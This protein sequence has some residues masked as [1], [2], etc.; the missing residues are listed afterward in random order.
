MDVSTYQPVVW[1]EEEA[2]E[3]ATVF[4]KQCDQKSEEV[5]ADV[6]ETK[7][8]VSQYPQGTSVISSI[9]PYDSHMLYWEM[10]GWR[11][12]HEFITDTLV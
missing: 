9:T 3:C 2:E 8:Q 1:V 6:T 4:V 7:C 5:C 12:F 10:T 11:G